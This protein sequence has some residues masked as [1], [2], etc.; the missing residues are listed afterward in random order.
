M[1]IP[2]YWKNK[3]KWFSEYVRDDYNEGR[4]LLATL[5]SGGVT[6]CDDIERLI[7]ALEDYGDLILVDLLKRK[8]YMFSCGMAIKKLDKKGGYDD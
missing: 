6:F 4:A 1:R 3:A 5:G 2:K 7:I 8:D